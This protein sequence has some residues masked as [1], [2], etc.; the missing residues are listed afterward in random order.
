MAEKNEEKT[1]FC[2]CLQRLAIYG[3][4]FAG[5]YAL[6]HFFL[7]F[8]ICFF[9]FLFHLFSRFLIVYG[10]SFICISLVTL[11]ERYFTAM[12][13]CSIPYAVLCAVLCCCHNR[14]CCCCCCS[15]S[16]SF[17]RLLRKLTKSTRLAH[18]YAISIKT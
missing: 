11:T 14:C 10:H 13:R 8:W 9:L 7:T 16:Y 15:F 6:V 12:L 4:L 18:R 17:L 1:K 3:V 5:Q 2:V